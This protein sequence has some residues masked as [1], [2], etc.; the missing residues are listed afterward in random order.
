MKDPLSEAI[1]R[2]TEVSGQLG[3]VRRQLERLNRRDRHTRIGLWLIMILVALTVA[4]TVLLGL[5]AVQANDAARTAS[6]AYAS[7]QALCR[8]SNVS[9]HQQ[10]GVWDEL[11][12]D[13]GPPKTKA[14]A[15]VETSFRAYVK[16]TFAPRDCA[17]LGSRR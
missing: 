6:H 9:R 12:D 15:R 16:R 11:L 5:V 2:V 13:L 14:A 17:A 7:N 8:A 1:A 10:I 3:A 4:L